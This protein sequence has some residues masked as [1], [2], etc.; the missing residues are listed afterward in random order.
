VLHALDKSQALFFFKDATADV[1]MQPDQVRHRW[2][3]CG[4]LELVGHAPQLGTI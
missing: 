4:K 3:T 1:E 2:M